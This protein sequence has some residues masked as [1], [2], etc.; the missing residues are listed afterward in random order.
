M[1]D[2]ALILRPRLFTETGL[3]VERFGRLARKTGTGGKDL[4]GALLING[5]GD[6]A[7]Y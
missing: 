1:L 6:L 3:A 7:Q 2:V 4:V 5:P